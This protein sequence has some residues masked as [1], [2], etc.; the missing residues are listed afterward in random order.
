MFWDDEI[1]ETEKKQ[2][3][4]DDELK[5][6][7]DSLM[8]DYLEETKKHLLSL[9]KE[10]KS[11]KKF[12]AFGNEITPEGKDEEVWEYFA[13]KNLWENIFNKKYRTKQAHYLDT[14]ESFLSETIDNPERHIELFGRGLLW[15]YYAKT[16]S[17][18]HGSF[19]YL[20]TD[21]PLV[22]LSKTVKTFYNHLKKTSHD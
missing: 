7:L 1:S 12:D 13:E 17:S 11:A 9:E 6:L 14:L 16:N 8:R 4:L 22:P 18:G 2:Q 19:A 15:R 10:L 20:K 5:K 21:D 3:L